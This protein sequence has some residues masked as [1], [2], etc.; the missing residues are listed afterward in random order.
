MMTKQQRQEAFDRGRPK[1]LWEG[2]PFLGSTYGEEEI[3]AAVAAIRDSMEVS[4][5][6]GFT[7]TTIV[8]FEEAFAAYVGAK[9]G[10]AV[11]SAGPGLDMAMRY[12]DL[13]P[14][15]EVIVPAINF[16][17]A[18]LAVVGAGGQIV[19]GEV[20]PR[21]LQLDPNDVEKRITPRTRAI[22]P[23]HMNGLSAPTDDLIEIGNRHPHDVH[24]PIPVIGD[25]ARACGAGYRGEKIGRKGL[26]TVFS[27]H[28]MKNITTLGEG[29]MVTTDDDGVAAYCRSTR[30][31]GGAEEVWGTSNV[32]TKPQAAVGLV[33]LRKLDG[34]IADRRRVAHRRDE[35]LEGIPELVLPYE[36]PDCEHSYYLYTCLVC[37]AWAGEKR[38]ALMAM[39][40]DEY[41]IKLLVAN[42]PA[43]EAR[44][45]LR[46]HT[47]GQSLPL[48]ENLGAR[49]CCVPIHP[50]MSDEDNEYICA[51]LVECVERLR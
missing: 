48:S 30:F 3:E 46:D 47:P 37:E 8:A 20:D 40:L 27:F 16:V 7:A 36:P 39:M 43:Y 44:T 23:V 26:L 11:N 50:A 10:I 5:G 31:Y 24:G 15:D 41:G 35:L 14:G 33:Q 17:A 45:F 38:D 42:R 32:M 21:T 4:R 49:I 6:F 9:H 12:L 25:A 1:T 51:S 19:W 28:T 2:E 13:K 34:F 29:G 18:P 22:F